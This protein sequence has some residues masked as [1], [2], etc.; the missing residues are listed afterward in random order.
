MATP[1]Y[2]LNPKLDRAR[3]AEE[4]RR[5]G[6]LHIAEFLVAEDA[7]RLYH[8][9]KGSD[10][11]RLIVNQGDKLFELDR[12][13]QAALSAEGRRELERAV[14][15]SARYGFQYLYESI[16]VPDEDSAREANGDD[17]NAFARF[18]SSPETLDFFRS[19]GIEADFADAQAT[20]YGLGHFLSVHDD[21]F[22]G[23]R[24][25]AAYV[26]NLTPNWRAE[27]GGLLMFHRDDGH[28][29]EALTPSFNALNLFAV[30]QPHSVSMVAPFAPARRYSVT[31]WLRTRPQA[32]AA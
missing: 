20:A 1:R 23:K 29:D 18:L 13:A 16:R 9:L 12:A 31:G 10:A 2:R 19:F 15:A 30:P 14:H 4:Y 27:W 21:D 3:L 32:E 8:F 25:K 6:R 11:W 26:F 7:E 22:P 28:I 24:R 17:L 5:A